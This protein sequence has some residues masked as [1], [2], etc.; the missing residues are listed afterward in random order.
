MGKEKE[1]Q[2]CKKTK[3]ISEFIMYRDGS[4]TAR[5]RVCVDEQV[6]SKFAIDEYD[7]LLRRRPKLGV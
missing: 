5:C 4:T 7:K 3:R 2:K 6:N 1:C